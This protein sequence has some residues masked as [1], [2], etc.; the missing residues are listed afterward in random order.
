MPPS[1][2]LASSRFLSHRVASLSAVLIAA[3]CDSPPHADTSPTASDGAVIAERDAPVEPE[4]DVSSA[5]YN[6]L[7]ELATVPGPTPLFERDDDDMGRRYVVGEGF[8]VDGEEGAPIPLPA[9]MTM[10]PAP[11]LAAATRSGCR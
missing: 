9:L 2:H 1:S 11:R 4:P 6:P 8:Y 7:M 5:F 10:T 3:A